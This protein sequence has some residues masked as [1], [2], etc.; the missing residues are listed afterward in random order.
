MILPS[1]HIS[2]M[3]NKKITWLLILQAWAML[4]VV[5]GH[6]GPA[7]TL[8]EYP[9]FARLL[10]D[11]AYSFHM[12]LFIMISGFLFYI[13]R[14]S[15][16]KW[17]YW[18]MLREKLVRFGIPFVFFTLFTMVLKSVF[19][20]QVERATT[21]SFAEFFHA[22]LYPYDGPM[23]EFWFLGA[24]M[25]YFALFPVWKV[26]LRNHFS[27][28][29]TSVVVMVCF[30]FTPDT[31]FLALHHA[32]YH[33]S[34]FWWGI[35]CAKLYTSKNVE[36]YLPGNTWVLLAGLLISIA[37]YILSVKIN[38]QYLLAV[39][40]ITLSFFCCLVLYKYIPWVFSGFRNYT[41]QI[42]LMGIF[43]Q[44]MVKMVRYRMDLAFEPVYFVSII[45]GLYVPVLIAVIAQKLKFKPLSLCLGLKV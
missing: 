31:S 11:F 23:R 5:I 16:E 8:E 39:F 38:A 13:T 30:F 12:Q 14:I 3:G 36:N 42:F 19:A 32:A 29:L 1:Q 34:F 22:I 9:P 25:W 40:G 33:V 6:A 2:H 4:W 45:A 7:N 17:T 35:L 44:E 15:K 41:Y 43:V 24:I 26:C 10:W 20:S 37:F 28:V 21:I 27:R 18:S